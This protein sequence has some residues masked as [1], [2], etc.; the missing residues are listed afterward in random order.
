MENIFAENCRKRAELIVEILFIAPQERMKGLLTSLHS[1]SNKDN[2]FHGDSY[3]ECFDMNT[4]SDFNRVSKEVSTKYLDTIP[5]YSYHLL[6]AIKSYEELLAIS[7]VESD[8]MSTNRLLQFIRAYSVNR[9]VSY[10]IS[11][12]KS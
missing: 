6:S 1:Y 5:Q 9:A 10:E 3:Q 2:V 7:L 8:E 11:L 12:D 4:G